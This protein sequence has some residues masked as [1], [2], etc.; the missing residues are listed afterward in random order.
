LKIYLTFKKISLYLCSELNKFCDNRLW[1]MMEILTVPR[2]L[3]T[4]LGEDSLIELMN[5]ANLQQKED[6]LIFVE[7][8]FERRLTE[9]I[10]KIN[11]RITKEILSTKTDLIKW[12]FIFWIG[13]IGAIIGILLAF[14][15]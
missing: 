2:P 14:F 8:K 10:S 7:E 9:E 12:M 13:Q 3:R 6:I 4:R 15:K 5:K 11:E 1:K